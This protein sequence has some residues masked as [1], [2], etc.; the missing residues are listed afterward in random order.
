MGSHPATGAEAVDIG[1][2]DHTF[3]AKIRG[4]Y[5]G[6]TGNVVV[7][8]PAGNATFSNVPPGSILPVA[9][10]KVIRTGTT[11]SNMVGLY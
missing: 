1:S 9:V 7:H 4:L 11:A 2:N 10:D 6:T 8:F 5:V 3:S